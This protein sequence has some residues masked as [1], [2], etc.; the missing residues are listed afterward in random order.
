MVSPT[1]Q[2]I[3]D[4]VTI[5]EFCPPAWWPFDE[6]AKVILF[7]DEY[8]RGKP[9]MH[10]C[11]MDMVRN[12]KLMGRKLPKH[13]RIFAADNPTGDDYLYDTRD[14]DPANLDRFKVYDFRPDED[15]WIDYATK[16]KFNDF[17][18]GFHIKNKNFL[19][20][21]SDMILGQKYPS[22]RSWERVS[23]SLNQ[24][25]EI[26]SDTVFAREYFSGDIGLGA[27]SRFVEY[28]KDSKKNISAG[29]IITDWNEELKKKIAEI[30]VPEL[31]HINQ[32]I[33]VWFEQHEDI[34]EDLE[35]KQAN[36]YVLNLERYLKT[37]PTETMYEFFEIISQN[38]EKG[39]KW[40]EM[41]LKFNQRLAELYSERISK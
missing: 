20:P 10:N 26:I 1:G 27:A 5:T 18:I 3:T 39:K 32:A 7:L 19:D 35:V 31:I 9:E 38:F 2:E 16:M 34:L 33:S 15:E 12:R 37:I 6:D 23:D 29:V 8:K 13:T 11:M 24:Y 36:V 22:R 40:P 25:P 41:V 28:L 14:I 30:P 21:P 17:V 4:E